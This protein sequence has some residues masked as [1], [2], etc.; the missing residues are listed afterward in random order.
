[1]CFSKTCIGSAQQQKGE[2]TRLCSP[3][4]RL[5]PFDPFDELRAGRLRA[6]A[7]QVGAARRTGRGGAANSKCQLNSKDQAD[8]TSKGRYKD[9]HSVEKYVIMLKY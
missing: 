6:T 2:G 1:L 9:K 7:R 3:S 5:R 4:F 8:H